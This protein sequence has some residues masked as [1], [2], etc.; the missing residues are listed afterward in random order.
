MNFNHC[1]K[2]HT[3]SIKGGRMKKKK[4]WKIITFVSAFS[5]KEIANFGNK[6]CAV[7]V[8]GHGASP[9]F[10]RKIFFFADFS[11]QKRQGPTLIRSM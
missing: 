5:E 8:K 3:K 6:K 7:G 4:S 11:Q 10:Q 9:L 1:S 2:A